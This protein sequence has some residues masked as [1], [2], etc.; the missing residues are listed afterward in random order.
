M[1]R[2]PEIGLVQLQ[3]RMGG[4]GERLPAMPPSPA[5]RIRLADGTLGYGY[6]SWPRQHAR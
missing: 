2:A 5:Q 1:I 3:A 6:G 4:I